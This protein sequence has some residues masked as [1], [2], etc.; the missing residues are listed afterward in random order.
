VPW[1][2]PSLFFFSFFFSKE[3][4]G[5]GVSLSLSLSLTHALTLCSSSLP[6]LGELSD[7]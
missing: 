7:K 4:E 2:L 5:K 6:V 3:E 1:S